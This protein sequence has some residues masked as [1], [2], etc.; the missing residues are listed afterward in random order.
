MDLKID[1][2]EIKVQSEESLVWWNT[3][4]SEDEREVLEKG[5]DSMLYNAC[6]KALQGARESAR[7]QQTKQVTQSDPQPPKIR[8]HHS[9]FPNDHNWYPRR[10]EGYYEAGYY[11][12]YSEYSPHG[13]DEMYNRH[14]NR[15]KVQRGVG[16]FEYHPPD[17]D[18]RPRRLEQSRLCRN[19]KR[20]SK[21]RTTPGSLS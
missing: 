2:S 12:P 14:L 13:F 3:L 5:I 10:E 4:L 15:P 7:R 1:N 11:P 9:K 20:S 16:N 17:D 8:N 6:Q 19:K 21:R 18:H